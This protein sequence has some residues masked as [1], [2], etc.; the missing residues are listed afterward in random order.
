MPKITK[1]FVDS[2]TP[3]PEKTLKYWDSELKGFGL[4]VLPSGRQTYCIEYRNLVRVKKRL[5]LGVHGQITTEEARE[6]AKKRLG[7]VAHG[8][9]PATDKRHMNT[10][11][12]ME[13]LAQNYLERHGYKK[14]PKSVYEDEKL[15]NNVIL[16]A[17]GRL[18]VAYVI[19]RDVES[20]HKSMQDRPYQANRALA[21]LSKMFSL[22]IA[23]NWRDDNPVLGIERYQE[24]NE[25][26]G[27]IKR[28]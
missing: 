18:K 15:L 13:D 4:I 25:T 19:R 7:Q 5:K 23:W 21:L 11:V 14:R 16:P 24:E 17:L 26:D 8:E 1:R 12:N 20:L 22:A 9:D 28:N 2:I 10:L 27:L 3:D 6:L